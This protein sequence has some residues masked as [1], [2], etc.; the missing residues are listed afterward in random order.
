MNKVILSIVALSALSSAKEAPIY[1]HDYAM[2]KKEIVM[3][4]QLLDNKQKGYPITVSGKETGNRSFFGSFSDNNDPKWIGYSNLKVR[5][6]HCMD[7]EFTQMLEKNG[8]TI[9]S[10]IGDGI[11][12]AFR[13]G[14]KSL[15]ENGAKYI[16]VQTEAKYRGDESTYDS[17]MADWKDRMTRWTKSGPP[18]EFS[19]FNKIW[20]PRNPNFT[21][22]QMQELYQWQM[23]NWKKNEPK[24]PTD[25]ADV[26]RDESPNDIKT[27]ESFS[28]YFQ[29]ILADKTF[30]NTKTHYNFND[31]IPEYDFANIPNSSISF[32]RQIANGCSSESKTNVNDALWFVG[33]VASL[34]LG[35][36]AAKAGN[37][38]L[39]S[40]AGNSSQAINYATSGNNKDS[41]SENNKALAGM[42]QVVR[43]GISGYVDPNYVDKN[44]PS[45]KVKGYLF[46]IEEIEEHLSYYMTIP[47]KVSKIEKN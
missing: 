2:S 6:D 20:Q 10:R 4:S 12:V 39:N 3:F 9:K 7:E 21:P 45:M 35:A 24:K 37:V 25:T 33:Q 44:E 32:H 18:E 30:I 46:P 29:T 22:T 17:K 14:V 27:G 38:G 36:S 8:F 28:N 15:K 11:V 47:Y 42:P 5:I 26:H 34:A 1:D 13:E 41:E 40:L 19:E 16:F 23:A 31:V 43:I